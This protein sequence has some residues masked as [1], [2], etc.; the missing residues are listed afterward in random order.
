MLARYDMFTEIAGFLA[1]RSLQPVLSE[2]YSFT[3]ED[4]FLL[5]KDHFGGDTSLLAFRDEVGRFS[6]A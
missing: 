1:D 2:N 4:D 5:G 3:S 6:Y